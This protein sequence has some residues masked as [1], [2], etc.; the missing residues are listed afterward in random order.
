MKIPPAPPRKR[1]KMEQIADMYR[2]HYVHGMAVA[3]IADKYGAKKA[4]VVTALV[5]F[6]KKLNEQFGKQILSP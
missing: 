3:Q 6:K 2:L 5:K 4:N 1:K